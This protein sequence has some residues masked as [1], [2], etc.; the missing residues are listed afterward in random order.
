MSTKFNGGKSQAEEYS[1]HSC[2]C[3]VR[4]LNCVFK[5]E[6][7]CR[8]SSVDECTFCIIFSR[9]ESALIHRGC[10]ALIFWLGFIIPTT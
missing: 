9:T 7:Y 5:P 10:P 4:L 2:T 6:Y 8:T 1:K 3:D